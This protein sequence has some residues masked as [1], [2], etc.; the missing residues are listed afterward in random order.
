MENLLEKQKAIEELLMDMEIFEGIET[1]LSSFNAFE[2][3]GVVNTEIRHSNVLAWLLN[4]KENHGIGDVFIKKLIQTLFYLNKN[5]ILK[6]N[7]T[8]FDISL[9]DYYDFNIRR[10]WKNIDILAVSDEN[11]LVLVIENKVWSKESKHQLKKYFD[12]VNRDFQGYSKVFVFLTP[13]GDSPSDEENWISF[14][15]KNVFDILKKSM[16]LK[17]DI[18]NQSVKVF[19]EQYLDVLRR[20]IV[21]DFELEKICREIYYKH[22]KALDLIFEYKPD[23]YS[24]ISDYIKEVVE[25]DSNVI[26]DSSTKTYVRFITEDLDTIIARKGSGWTSSNR[27]LL[28]EVQNRND[29]I[30]LKLIIGPGD[31]II[32]NKIFNIATQNKNLFK[33]MLKTLTPQYSQIF[34]KEIVPKKYISKFE[35]DIEVIQKRITIELEN[36]INREMKEIDNCIKQNFV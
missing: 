25:A 23:I 28:Y 7:L 15:Y 12:I 11:K 9:M 22:Q 18:I 31:D 1:K 10:E 35:N 8:L 21:G 29:K 16:E 32:R 27:I 33:G 3:L 26:Y 5:T 6:S 19:I 17:K 34:S 30:V 14:N 24:E 4:P 2:T 36:F 20:Y 13:Y